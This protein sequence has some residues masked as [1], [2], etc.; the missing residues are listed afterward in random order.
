MV[1]GGALELGVIKISGLGSAESE[2]VMVESE[3]STSL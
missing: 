2:I 3:M 1:P